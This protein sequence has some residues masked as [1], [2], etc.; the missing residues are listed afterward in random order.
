VSP[1]DLSA[2]ILHHLGVDF[3][4]QYFDEFQQMHQRLS[5]GRVIDD[6]G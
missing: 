5:P 4:Q 1:A 6:L 2:T 3:T